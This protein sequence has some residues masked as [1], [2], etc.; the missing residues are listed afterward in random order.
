MLFAVIRH[1]KPN[2][3]GLRLSERPKH[4]IYLEGV[5]SCITSGGALV[6]D[7]GQQNGS[8][9]IIDVANSTAAEDFAARDPYVE[10]GL[11]ANTCISAF[12]PVFRDGARI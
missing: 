10:A 2:C 11:F 1:D 8:I 4:L 12:R 6:D 9:L 3:I 7:S 5:M